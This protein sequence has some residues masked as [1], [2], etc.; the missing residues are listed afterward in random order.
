MGPERTREVRWIADDAALAREIGRIG[1]GPVAFD[2]EA[3]SFHHYR[4]RL[5]L[6]QVSFGETDLVVDPL[7]GLDLGLLA[8][9]LADPSIPK[10][11]HGA[12]FDV[13]LLD[14]ERGLTIAGLFDTMVAARLAGHDAVGLAA[15]LERRFGVRLDK[16][17]QRADWSLR[18]LTPR[19]VE[20]AV[21][22]T[23]WLAP[24]ATELA[25]ELERLAR[26]AWAEEAFRR[27]EALR[28]EE[29]PA[30]RAWMRIKGAGGLDRR[31]LA[32]LRELHRTRDR[33]A[34]EEDVAPFRVLGNGAA[35]EIA[36]RRPRSPRDL[37]AIDG[38]GPRSYKPEGVERILSAVAA[39]LA[40]PESS[41]PELPERPPPPDPAFEARLRR[42]LRA[43]DAVASELALDPGTLAPRAAIAD[44]LVRLDRGLG[45]SPELM[46]W[47]AGFVREALDRAGER[48]SPGTDVA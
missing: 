27:I 21:A 25:S 12:D 39:A 28:F 41:L 6:V 11:L 36:R 18:P 34:R 37:R 43:R 30:D 15:L 16:S 42:V 23:R 2:T 46:S 10:L 29:P 38:L 35:I 8:P 17:L 40:L 33:V 45:P 47:Q 4:E 22:D 26:T 20:Y 24:L 3:D 31:G 19:M 7:S 32:I 1:R 44:T 5:C 14:R 9:I 48:L 13:R